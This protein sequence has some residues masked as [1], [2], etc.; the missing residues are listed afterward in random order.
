MRCLSQEAARLTGGL[1]GDEVLDQEGADANK[2]G[3]RDR[4]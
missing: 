3:V 2:E 1:P 4:N